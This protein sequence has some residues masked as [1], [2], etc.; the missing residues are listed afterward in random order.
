M[1]MMIQI[2]MGKE[3]KKIQSMVMKRK[4]SH[5]INITVLIGREKS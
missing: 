4:E 1:I 5:K 3:N 2:K